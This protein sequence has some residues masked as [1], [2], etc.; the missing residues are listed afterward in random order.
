MA[1]PVTEHDA[2]YG[3]A[4]AKCPPPVSTGTPASVR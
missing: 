1:D 3:E 2:R 4:G